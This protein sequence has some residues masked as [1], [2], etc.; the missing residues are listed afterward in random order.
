MACVWTKP[1]PGSTEPKLWKP[2]T[3]KPTEKWCPIKDGIPG[4]KVTNVF[5]FIDFPPPDSEDEY[6]F[7]ED[8]I[9]GD[10]MDED[11]ED[12]AAEDEKE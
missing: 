4:K 1:A 6:D 9:D 12:D 2:D 3:G 7:D 8:D 5:D 11:E 10:D